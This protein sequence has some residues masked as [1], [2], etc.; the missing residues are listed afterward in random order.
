MLIHSLAFRLVFQT[1][2]NIAYYKCPLIYIKDISYLDNTLSD[3]L[4]NT[5]KE[6]RKLI[7]SYLF[8]YI[9]FSNDLLLAILV[10]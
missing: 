2:N 1:K 7:L 4:A 3:I 8:L 9:Q 10:A 6:A 5:L